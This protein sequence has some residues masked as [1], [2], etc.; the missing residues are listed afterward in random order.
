MDETGSLTW[1]PLIP[2]PTEEER[3]KAAKTLYYQSISKRVD[4]YEN[5]DTTV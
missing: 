4:F 5:F 1:K 2:R 3:Q